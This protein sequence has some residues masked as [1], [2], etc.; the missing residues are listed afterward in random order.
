MIRLAGKWV[1][2]LHRS[3]SL[4]TPLY[5][6]SSSS[7]S[8]SPYHPYSFSLFPPFLSFPITSPTLP[9]H[10]IISLSMCLFSTY[11]LLLYLSISVSLPLLYNFFFSP[12]VLLSNPLDAIFTHSFSLLPLLY[13]FFLLHSFLSTHLSHPLCFVFI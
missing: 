1:I 4:F 13:H 5:H 8:F 2:R 6:S 11:T 3:L 12:F 9:L 10:T 7:L